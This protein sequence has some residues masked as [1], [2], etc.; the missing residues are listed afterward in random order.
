VGRSQRSPAKIVF[1][2]TQI[3]FFYEI[4]IWIFFSMARMAVGAVNIAFTLY[5]NILQKY[6]HLVFFI[7]FLQKYTAV[8]ID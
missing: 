4:S 5:R 1:L 2:R 3:I 8:S 7:G 6:W